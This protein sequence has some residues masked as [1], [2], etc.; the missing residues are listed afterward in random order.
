MFQRA[1][2]KSQLLIEL[3]RSIQDYFDYDWNRFT[4]GDTG[5]DRAN[6]YKASLQNKDVETLLTKVISDVK[7]DNSDGPLGTS[8]D[9]RKRLMEGLCRYLGITNAEIEKE[10]KDII[11][12]MARAAVGS[13]MMFVTV[14]QFKPTVMLRLID[15]RRDNRELNEVKQRCG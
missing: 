5:K 13:A 8:K 7:N 12:N 1:G 2:N 15:G 14:D 6:N 10:A 11:I 4:R 9:L 3:E